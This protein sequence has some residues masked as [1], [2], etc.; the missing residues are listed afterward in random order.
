[1]DLQDAVLANFNEYRNTQAHMGSA[2][3]VKVRSHGP[4]GRAAGAKMV[5][6]LR[7]G[8]KRHTYTNERWSRVIKGFA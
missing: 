1:M 4:D 2:F 5:L 6:S 7:Y 3:E 8:F